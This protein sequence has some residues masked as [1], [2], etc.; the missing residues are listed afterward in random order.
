[1]ILLILGI[2]LWWGA[3]LFKRLA[4]AARANLG[5]KG[6]GPI[7]LVLFGS[8]ALMVLGYRGSDVYD[9]A[10][11]PAALRHINNLLMLVA[12]FMMSP[13]AKKGRLLH[14]MR[15]PMLMGVG[16]WALAHLLV[17]W[18]IASFLLFGS[19]LIWAVVEIKVINRAEPDWAPGPQGTLSKDAMFL[20]GSIV[21]L[22]VIGYVHSLA[23]LVPFGG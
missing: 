22:G 18:D 12:L 5:D 7:A 10:A 3:H 17:N 20:V 15:H 4:P 16:T 1:M 13:A 2:L 9:L 23:G 14:G 6:K 11:P 8:L 19:M 21:L